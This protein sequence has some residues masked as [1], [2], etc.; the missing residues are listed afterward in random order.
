[1]GGKPL[2]GRREYNY[3]TNNA[4]ECGKSKRSRKPLNFP[5]NWQLTDEFPPSGSVKFTLPVSREE[6]VALNLG[7]E[8]R[9]LHLIGQFHQG[10]SLGGA[11]RDDDAIGIKRRPETRNI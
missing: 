8:F 9:I 11:D 5:P 10:C 4:S 3:S 6:K 7:G 2:D 1:M